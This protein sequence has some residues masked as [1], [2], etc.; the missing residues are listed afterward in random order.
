MQPQP[1][2][3]D[4]MKRC[5]VCKRKIPDARV[6]II[7]KRVRTCSRLCAKEH[8]RQQ[9]LDHKDRARR[10]RLAEKARAAAS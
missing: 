8:E 1:C 3:G 9:Q 2:Y 5:A 10:V 7:G 4:P 6:E